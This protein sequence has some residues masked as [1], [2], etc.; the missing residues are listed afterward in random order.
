[1]SH[2]QPGH[3]YDENLERQL[4]ELPDLIYKAKL[5]WRTQTRDRKRVDAL[6]RAR[7]KMENHDRNSADLKALIESDST[8][9]EACLKEDVAEAEYERLYEKHMSN[10]KIAS[11]RTAF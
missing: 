8:H 1:M 3:H 9:Y 5:E 11:L 2:P 10:K 6:L 4:E 7:F